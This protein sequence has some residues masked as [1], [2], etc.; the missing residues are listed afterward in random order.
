M[1]HTSFFIVML[2]FAAF[3]NTSNAQ[4]YYFNF[5]QNYT[6]YDYKNSQGQRNPNIKSDNGITLDFGYRWVISDDEKWHYKAGLSF[7][8][9]NAKGQNDT[10][11]YSWVTNYLGIQN[12]LSYDIYTSSDEDLIINLNSGFTASKIIKGEQLI[13]NSSYD[14]TNENE[15]K[16]LFLQ[17]HLGVENEIKINDFVVLGIGY[18][19]SKAI[20]ASKPESESLNFINN[21]FYINFKYLIY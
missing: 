16:G 5:G 12:S 17:P 14:L 21:A 2:F 11:N 18:R 10:F 7:Q 19:F 1:K 6:K 4:G 20:R 15:F 8:Q 9:F 13:N 3:S